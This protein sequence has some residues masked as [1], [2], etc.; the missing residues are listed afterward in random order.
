MLKGFE[1]F[2]SFFITSFIAFSLQVSAQNV[3]MKFGKIENSDL[4]IDVYP[5]DTGASAVILADVGK[6]H[7]QY[8]QTKGDFELVFERHTRI[9]VLNK[10]G[11]KWADVEIPLYGRN[12]DKERVSGLKGYTYNLENGKVIK[13]KLDKKSVFDDLKN[14]YWSLK[15]FTMPN[16][17]EGSVIEYT[18]KVYSDFLFNLQSWYFQYEIPAIWSEYT[19]VVP[20][21]FYYKKLGQGYISMVLAE[22]DK[23][24]ESIVFSSKEGSNTVDFLS[25]VYHYATKDVPAFKSE[26]YMTTSEDFIS[27]MDFELASIKYPRD[28]IRQIMDTWETI[29]KEL[30]EHE[31]FMIR[32]RRTNFLKAQMGAVLSGANTPE[33]KIEAIYTYVQQNIKWDEKNGM[34]TSQSLKDT[35]NKRVGNSADINLLLIAMLQ[36]AGLEADPVILST[37][38]NGRVMQMYPII[39]KF[40]YV[41][42]KVSLD[43][44]YF[45]LDATDPFR[46]IGMLPYNCL[47]GQGF[48]I[49]KGMEE[50]VDLL[51][52]EIFM[53]S[54]QAT[55]AFNDEM[56][57]T[58][59]IQKMYK[60]FSANRKRISL[61]GGEE[62]YQ[63]ELE[64]KYEGWELNELQFKNKGEIG[65]PFVEDM[66]VVIPSEGEMGD[67]I[68]YLDPMIAGD[69]LEEN[70]FKSEKRTYPVDFGSPIRGQYILN[71]D[72]PDGYVVEDMP[73]NA[74][75]ALP[76]NGGRFTYAISVKGK[77]LQLVS[78][79]LIRKTLFVP[80]EY[81]SLKEFY[82]M[83]I[84]KCA[85]KIVLKKEGLVLSN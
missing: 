5:L 4:E 8:N 43:G 52:K 30:L 54:H 59:K 75:L 58:G 79:F 55:L 27:K 9:K 31:K 35:F 2:C 41:I 78:S 18:Y 46:S 64:E 19:A 44:K 62:K 68:I 50:W 3:K 11:F 56:E 81:S 17:R 33:E 77:R 37:R 82:N 1:G 69:K 72:L 21:Y 74:N 45:L 12:S 26:S 39:T 53:E 80:E 42:S 29:I 57:L 49:K 48:V 34:F 7:I 40:N 32:L 15:K 51:N 61:S 14:E 85:E 60:G 38:N 83:Y 10:N 70:P 20:E 47:N 24:S 16:V 66:D 67:D 13:S 22:E 71:L 6:S 73:E 36:E 23:K 28:P 63:E 76:E 25:T 84:A 65:K